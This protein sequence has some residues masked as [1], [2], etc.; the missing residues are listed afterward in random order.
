MAEAISYTAAEAAFVLRESVRAV[1]KAL[2]DGPVQTKLISKPGGTVRTIEWSDLFYLYAVRVLRDEL[3]PKSRNEFYHALKSIQVGRAR[4]VKFGR[5]SVAIE[6]LRTEV[7]AR[8]RELAELSAKVEFRPDG[9]AVLKGTSVE[10]YRLAALLSGGMSVEEV[11]EDY[12]S[13]TTE[14]I[15]TARA[16][17]EAHPKTGRPF[18]RTTAKRAL[19][20]AGLEA[21]DEVLGVEQV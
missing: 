5:L 20:G 12:P 17:A 6:D 4:E 14:M 21:L 16:Y 2:D 9:E 3:T 18:P 15:E 19:R 10:V 13:L 7:E 11:Q 8:S 1:K